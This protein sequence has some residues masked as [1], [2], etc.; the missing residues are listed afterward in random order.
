M[1]TDLTHIGHGGFPCLKFQQLFYLKNIF[2]WH[3]AN[4][5]LQPT[6]EHINSKGNIYINLE[7][8]LHKSLH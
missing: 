1:V 5:Q 7:T 2:F 4:H 3:N 6:N 8:P